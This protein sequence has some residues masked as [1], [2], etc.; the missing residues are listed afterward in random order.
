L[1]S[2]TRGKLLPTL[3]GNP[4]EVCNLILTTVSTMEMLHEVRKGLFFKCILAHITGETKFKLNNTIIDTWEDIKKALEENYTTKHALDYTAG[5]LFTARQYAHESI[6]E[7]SNR[8]FN[9]S[10]ELCFEVK[11]KLTAMSMDNPSINNQLY[12]LRGGNDLI[13]ELLKGTFVN[14]LKDDIIKYLLQSKRDDDVTPLQLIETAGNEES[15]LRSQR[16]RSHQT[17]SSG[18]ITGQFKT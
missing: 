15:E 5:T 1:D 7:W 14:G 8:L 16:F 2:N 11:A 12:Y 3:D 17:W 9:I 6:T 18:P 13:A 10:R 4:K